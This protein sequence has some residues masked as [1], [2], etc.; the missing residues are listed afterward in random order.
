MGEKPHHCA[1]GTPDVADSSAEDAER[2]R[3][4]VMREKGKWSIKRHPRVSLFVF[5]KC[6]SKLKHKWQ[7]L[8]QEKSLAPHPPPKAALTPL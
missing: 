3:R 5:E 2:E 8:K 1:A 7:P 4:G 6:N